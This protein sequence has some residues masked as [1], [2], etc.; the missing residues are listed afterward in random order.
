MAKPGVSFTTTASFPILFATATAAFTDASD[1][2]QARTI[3][4]SFM[5]CGGLKKWR[6][7]TRS[8]RGT[9]EAI[10]ETLSDDVLVARSASSPQISPSFR[11]ISRFMSRSS[12]AASMTRS[13]PEAADA[14]SPV[15]RIA[16]SARSRS[17][18]RIFPLPTPVSRFARILSRPDLARSP[19]TS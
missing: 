2:C 13:A 1:V 11:K 19:V 7:T 16:A 12:G 17:P 8:G 18:G 14:R 10:F 3:S 6:P 5:M 4:I 9:A 15:V